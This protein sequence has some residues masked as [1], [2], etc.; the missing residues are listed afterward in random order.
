[1]ATMYNTKEDLVLTVIYKKDWLDKL[2]FE[3]KLNVK[4]K[5]SGISD[6][7]SHRE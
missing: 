6:F 3:V 5:I 4:V 2:A 7:V 1:M